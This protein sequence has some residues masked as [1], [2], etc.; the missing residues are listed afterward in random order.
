MSKQI[1]MGFGSALV[2]LLVAFLAGAIF[3]TTIAVRDIQAQLKYPEYEHEV[4]SVMDD[5]W[6]SEE[7][8]RKGSLGWQIVQCRRAR[9]DDDTYGYE[10]IWRRRK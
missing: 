8:R 10:C 4:V 5:Q 3:R 7:L 6:S 9:S 2:V 1:L